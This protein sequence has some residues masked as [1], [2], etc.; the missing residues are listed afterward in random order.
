MGIFVTEIG[1]PE[2]R[3]HRHQL[4]D[5]RT[6]GVARLAVLVIDHPAGEKR[7]MI[8]KRPFL[9]DR[10]RDFDS[11]GNGEVE[12]V[13]A[14]A[15]ADVNQPG[16]LIHGDEIGRH[17][18]HLEIVALAAK[19][20]GT[21]RV[22]ETLGGAEPAAR[23]DTSGRFDLLQELIGENQSFADQGRTAFLDRRDFVYAVIVLRTEGDGAAAGNGP[24]RRRPDDDRRPVEGRAAGFFDRKADVKRGRF[25]LQIFDLGLRQ[26]GLLDHRP[27]HRF[28]ASKQSAVH[29]ELA[30]FGHDPGFRL[31]G[32]RGV[33][34]VPIA[35]HTEAL[36]LV[37][38]NIDP[39]IGELAAFAAELDDRHLVLVLALGAILLLDLP[40][41]RQTVA[42]PAGH[43][44]G[45]LAHHLLRAVDHVLQDLVEGMADMKM[46]VRIG[47]TVMQKEL[48]AAGRLCTQPPPEIHFRP[49]RQQF[50]L[51][52]RQSSFHREIGPRQANRVFIVDAHGTGSI[53]RCGHLPP[54]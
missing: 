40:F 54:K 26:R 48:L 17:H 2:Q 52:L 12:I 37:A 22:P 1:L 30:D 7:H 21:D 51:A 13:G 31:V 39:M 9:T 3:A 28:V 6:V 44:V 34:I 18:G 50:G 38:L 20:M 11:V 36:E 32:H 16:A 8:V 23:F 15:G 47:R 35:D 19:R 10:M 43:V 49:A 33:G 24:R 53:A 42:I 25:M 46:P 27:E 41:D 5:D 14:V 29:Q 4:A 45:V